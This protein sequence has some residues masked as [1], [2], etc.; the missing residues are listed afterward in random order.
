M[1]A[2]IAV[3]SMALAVSAMAQTSTPPPALR[4]PTKP[5]AA[6]AAAVNP[7]SV[8]PQAPLFQPRQVVVV[9]GERFLVW[10]GRRYKAG[11][12]IEGSR[13]E[14]I[15]ESEIWMHGVEGTRKLSLFEGVEKRPPRTTTPT[16]APGDEAATSKKGQKK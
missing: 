13:I 4:D 5:P 3:F 11:D 2:L 16:V 7:P 14:R 9:N 8:Q 10:N 12:V 1:R 15:G 6:Y